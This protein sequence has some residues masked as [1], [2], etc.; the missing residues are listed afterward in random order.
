[1][2]FASTL[3]PAT[4]LRRYKRFLADVELADGNVVTVHVANPGAMTGLQSAGSRVWLSRSRNAARKLPYSWELIEVDFGT[5]PEL[6]GVN[7][8]HPNTIVA[9]SLAA[10]AISELAGYARTRRE[11]Q[12]G[13]ASRVDFVLDDPCS[14]M[15]MPQAERP[16]CYV[17][18][19]NVHLMRR[20]G[21]A[22]FP[23]SVTARGARHLDELAAI[24]SAGGRAVM[25]FVVQIASATSFSLAG[26]IDPAYAAAFAR[27]RL[28]GVEALAYTCRIELTGITLAGRIPIAP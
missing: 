24:A 2:H 4:L 16:P 27:A 13:Q 10:G 5:G 11:V 26:D 23:D 12:Y 6:V 20:A 28:A 15:P 18:V 3:E 17:E 1:M 21:L 9:E 7:T 25:L 14:D 22:E 19:K 8:S